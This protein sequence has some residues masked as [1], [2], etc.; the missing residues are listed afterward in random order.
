MTRRL[1]VQQ[2]AG[3]IHAARANH[4]DLGQRLTL[5]AGLAIEI[6]NP[7]RKP[8]VAG[9]DPRDHGV[10][11]DREAA[12]LQ[13]EWQ[14]VI[15]GAEEG[16]R[17]AAGAAVPAVVAGGES[18]RRT[19]HVRPSSGND[20]QPELGHAPH[21]QALAAAR[22]RRRLQELAARQHF[23]VVRA[24]ADANQLLHLVVVRRDLRV[25]DR[26]GDLPAVTLGGLEIHLRIAEAH[27]APDIRLAAV[28]PDA[29]ERERAALGRHVGLFVG[30]EKELWRLLAARRAL[31]RLPGLHVGPELRSIELVPG[32][33]Q[34]DVDALLGEIPG[35]HPAGGAAADDDDGMDSRGI[36][37]LH[38][39]C[40]AFAARRPRP[41]AKAEAST[42]PD[43]G[44]ADR[45]VDYGPRG[46]RSMPHCHALPTTSAP[47]ASWS[48]RGR[49]PEG[50]ARAGRPARRTTSRHATGRG[51]ARFPPRGHAGRI[52]HLLR[53]L[54]RSRRLAAPFPP[55]PR[56]RRRDGRRNDCRSVSD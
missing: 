51:P 28:P 49:R 21:H 3:R 26:P 12:G 52:V 33:E 36:D 41:A 6:L 34:Q 9:E 24:A 16:R 53:G 25:L 27:P 8:V 35:R 56:R 18:A 45:R 50:H 7:A 5:G 31:L 38:F 46:G 54:P 37:D 19:R 11:L 32:I 39:P 42:L 14:E 20:R 29:R 30:I 40:S 13:R 44:L 55:A 2:D 4:D 10:G 48:T 15:R 47:A 23:R 22:R 43:Q 17:I 1:R